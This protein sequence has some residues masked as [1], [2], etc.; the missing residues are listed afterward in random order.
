MPHIWREFLCLFFSAFSSSDRFKLPKLGSSQSEDQKLLPKL[1]DSVPTEPAPATPAPARGKSLFQSTWL[2]CLGSPVTLPPY[3]ACPTT[4]APNPGKTL[5]QSTCPGYPWPIP[6]PCSN[7]AN[8]VK[9]K[10][11]TPCQIAILFI[12][13]VSKLSLYC[14]INSGSG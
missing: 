8:P 13:V 7:P 6:V 12:S 5:S 9:G 4:P 1:K 11:N 2:G 3:S 10:S 14:C